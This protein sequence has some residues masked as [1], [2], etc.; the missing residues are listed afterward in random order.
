[1]WI[2]FI[3]DIVINFGYRY[4]KLPNWEE[5]CDSLK[6]HENFRFKY[7]KYTIHF[8]HVEPKNNEILFICSTDNGYNKS[9]L[10]KDAQELINS[11]QIDGKSLQEVYKQFRYLWE[12]KY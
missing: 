7:K 2:L 6:K 1:M 8:T 5:F 11:V 12:T 10:F 3:T 9:K 4:R